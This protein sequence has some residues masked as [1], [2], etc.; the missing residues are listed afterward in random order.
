MSDEP[1]NSSAKTRAFS[2]VRE[3]TEI[4][5][6]PRETNACTTWR[7]TS[8]VPKTKILVRSKDPNT[9]LARSTTIFPKLTWPCAIPVWVRAQALA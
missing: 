7:P 9:R 4:W 3:A 1:A 8:P 5:V 6:A 2:K